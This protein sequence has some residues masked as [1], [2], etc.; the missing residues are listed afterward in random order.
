MAF[1]DPGRRFQLGRG[2]DAR[3]SNGGR[4]ILFWRADTLLSLPMGGGEV[5]G[6]GVPRVLFVLDRTSLILGDFD[7]TADGQRIL[8]RVPNPDAPARGIDVVL[9]WFNVLRTQPRS[10]GGKP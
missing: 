10:Q 6:R 7:A 4:E 2:R 5:G 1:P 8:V 9:N 3:W